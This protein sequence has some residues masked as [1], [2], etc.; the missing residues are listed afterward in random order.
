MDF[1]FKTNKS[2]E[3]KTFLNKCHQLGLLGSEIT[4]GSYL[5]DSIETEYILK[6]DGIVEEYDL[7]GVIIYT[8]DREH[9]KKEYKHLLGR[10]F[11]MVGLAEKDD[12]AKGDVPRKKYKDLNKVLQALNAL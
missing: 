9:I 11:T 7:G 2:E 6:Q 4:I 3:I 8:D 5:S 12:I 1:L 10:N